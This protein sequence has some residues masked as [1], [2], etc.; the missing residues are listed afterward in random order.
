MAV[1]APMLPT[2][3]PS[4]TP[5]PGQV[6]INSLSAQPLLRLIVEGLLLVMILIVCGGINGTAAVVKLVSG[7]IVVAVL[8]LAVIRI[9]TF[10]SSA[11]TSIQ[12]TIVTL[13]AM[14]SFYGT[15][16]L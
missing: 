3:V 16:Q 1:V 15:A 6:T 14:P 12:I 4:K 7:T 9:P 10:T 13:Q 5:A 2:L 11:N 8:L